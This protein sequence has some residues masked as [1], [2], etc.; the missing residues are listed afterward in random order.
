MLK[1][2]SRRGFSA[3]ELKEAVRNRYGALARGEARSCGL[4]GSC[5]G[6]AVDYPGAALQGKMTRMAGYQRQD[7]EAV[8]P[9]AASCSLGC[10]N[11]VAMAALR[12]GDVVLDIGSGAGL[13]V[14]LASRRVG[15]AGRV[16][17]L[18][19]TPEMIERARHNAR[20]AGVSNVEFRLGDAEDMPVEDESVDCIISN[21]VINLAP[22]KEK[23]FREAYRVLRPGGRLF[24]SDIVTRGLPRELRESVSAWTGC[25]AG[26]MEEEDYLATVRQAGFQQVEVAGR[27]ELKAHWLSDVVSDWLRDKAGEEQL[28]ITRL[29]EDLEGKIAS[30]YVSA[31][32]GCRP[33]L[34]NDSL[35][36]LPS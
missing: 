13:D 8:P 17:G 23:V 36:P 24:I 18:D 5:C 28:D 6:P 16:I 26:A 19:L 27:L 30:V 32:K 14:L 22:N 29:P 35:D 21:C 34:S 25:V 3:E 11:P 2:R 12:E 31:V 20:R 4:S 10:G 15:P 33:R 9:E 1:D 7:L